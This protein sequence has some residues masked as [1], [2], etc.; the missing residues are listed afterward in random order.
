MRSPVCSL[1]G[2]AGPNVT[3]TIESSSQGPV[4]I[5]CTEFLGEDAVNL[6]DAKK[7][8]TESTN[9]GGMIPAIQRS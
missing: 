6:V 9:G 8:E 7:R 2:D 3:L 5:E 4:W 1:R